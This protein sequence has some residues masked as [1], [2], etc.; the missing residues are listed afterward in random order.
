ML[1]WIDLGPLFEL[2]E[3]GILDVTY[4][5]AAIV[6][7]TLDQELAPFAVFEAAVRPI[8]YAH[9]V[10][11]SEAL[12]HLENGDPEAD[13]AYLQVLLGSIVPPLRE[14]NF[15]RTGAIAR[16]F[17]AD[18]RPPRRCSSQKNGHDLATSVRSFLAPAAKP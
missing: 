6:L 10:K 17:L 5:E 12:R 4:I 14:R 3:V 15:P 2:P 18:G 16:K 8:F 11:T 1:G 9:T 13:Y 7:G